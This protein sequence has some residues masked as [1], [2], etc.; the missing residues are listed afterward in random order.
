MWMTLSISANPI[1]TLAGYA[2]AASVVTV[3]SSAWCWAFYILII[4][5]IAPIVYLFMEN[6]SILDV[7]S[8]LRL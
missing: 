2:L 7:K 5:M 1:G 3:S 8:H 4:A 6:G